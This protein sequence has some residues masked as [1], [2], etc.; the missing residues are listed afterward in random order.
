MNGPRRAI[1]LFVPPPVDAHID[2]IRHR[3]DPVMAGRIGAH[4]TLVHDVADLGMA[5]ELITVAADRAPFPVRLTH[6][7]RWGPS[8]YGVFLHVDDHAGGIAALHRQ[9]ADLEAPA[10]ARVAYRPHVT[11]VHGRT[12]TEGQADAA[13]SALD[14]FEAGWEVDVAGVDLVELVE[15]R[16]RTIERFELRAAPVAD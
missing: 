4:I 11:L 16:W 13:W 1:V 2:E 10:W 15:P 5:R 12:V 14:G 7:D 9:V 6:A 3:F 8:R